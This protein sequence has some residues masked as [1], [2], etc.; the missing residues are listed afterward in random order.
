MARLAEMLPLP[1]LRLPYVFTTELGPDGRGHAGAPGQLAARADGRGPPVDG[2]LRVLP[3]PG[4]PDHHLRRPG[5]VGKTTLAAAIA[6]EG[7]RLGRRAC[8]VTIDPAKR[9]ADALGL[10]AADQRGASGRRR[11]EPG[12]ASC[13][14]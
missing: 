13:G 5:G 4:P 2:T 14:P 1:Q 11:L 3:G 6:L 12:R 9:L 10:E 7:A 8:V